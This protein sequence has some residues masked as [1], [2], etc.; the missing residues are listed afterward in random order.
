MLGKIKDICGA[1]M[2]VLGQKWGE[3][4]ST[5]ESEK[6]LGS[7]A[8]NYIS[9]TKPTHHQKVLFVDMYFFVTRLLYSIF[10]SFV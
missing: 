6:T 1:V 3:S 7:D 10:P 4:C 2:F 9:F 5:E 8:G